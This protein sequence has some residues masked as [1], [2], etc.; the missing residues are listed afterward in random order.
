MRQTLAH[1]HSSE[2]K[3]G[4]KPKIS[5]KKA[6]KKMEPIFTYEANPD[7]LGLQNSWPLLQ[8]DDDFQTACSLQSDC[9]SDWSWGEMR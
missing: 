5:Y 4:V 7:L 1:K 6:G 8:G 2:K 9:R 3:K